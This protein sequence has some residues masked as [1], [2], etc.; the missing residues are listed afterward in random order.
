MNTP[1]QKIKVGL[2]RATG[3]LEVFDEETGRLLAIQETPDEGLLKQRREH[4]V[5]RLLPNG[6][7]VLVQSSIDPSK[8]AEFN[9]MEYS[10]YV[11]DLLCEKITEGESLTDICKQPG[12][13]NYATLCRWKKQVPDIQKQIDQAR[14]DRAEMMRDQAWQIAKDSKESNVDSSKLKVQ[15]AQW[16]AQT[17]NKEKFGNAKAQVELNQPLQIIVNTGI[18]REVKDASTAQIQTLTANTG[19]SGVLRDPTSSKD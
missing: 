15:T 8:L 18:V 7:A 12:F 10:S 13:P 14:A 9:F 6:E 19:N 1:T 11:V 16:L 17:D 4:L 5:E 3:L 2:N